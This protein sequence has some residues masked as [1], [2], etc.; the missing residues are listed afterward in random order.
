MHVVLLDRVKEQHGDF[1]GF[2]LNVDL[3]AIWEFDIGFFV[4]F[5]VGLRLSEDIMALAVL[6]LDI[7]LEK[8]VIE[9]SSMAIVEFLLQKVG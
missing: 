2:F 5:H 3:F 9:I 6:T 8:E 4:D 1:V 7:V